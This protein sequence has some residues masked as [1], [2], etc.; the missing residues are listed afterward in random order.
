MLEED[1]EWVDVAQSILVRCDPA[2]ESCRYRNGRVQTSGEETVGD[3]AGRYNLDDM[4]LVCLNKVE[5]PF[6]TSTSKLASGTLVLLPLHPS[7]AQRRPDHLEAAAERTRVPELAS[8]TADVAVDSNCGAAPSVEF[9]AVHGR[10][11]TRCGLK[12]RLLYGF[13]AVRSGACEEWLGARVAVECVDARLLGTVACYEPGSARYHILL[14]AHG[15]TGGLGDRAVQHG[16]VSTTL[17]SCDVHVVAAMSAVMCMSSPAAP[18]NDEEEHQSSS[19][20]PGAAGPSPMPAQHSPDTAQLP[21]QR[22]PAAN[23]VGAEQL[24]SL[25]G[26]TVTRPFDGVPGTVSTLVP[27]S[28]VVIIEWQD[29]TICMSR[30]QRLCMRC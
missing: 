12:T 24:A 19:F 23:S 22:E 16:V 29:G 10:M 13:E 20:M 4:K 5:H 7:L 14:D 30:L 26:M 9:S 28:D 15:A 2:A 21:V 18:G 6:I 27:G 1:E 17:P 11:G 3:I 25:V 8:N